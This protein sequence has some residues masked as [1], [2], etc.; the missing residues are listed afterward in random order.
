MATKC[1]FI[2]GR[3]HKS[4]LIVDLNP[5]SATNLKISSGEVVCF[6]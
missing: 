2:T 4:Q 6:M 3:A 1:T 5:S